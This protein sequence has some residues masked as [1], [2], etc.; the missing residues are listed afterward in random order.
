LLKANEENHENSTRILID[1]FRN[2]EQKF[3]LSN[4][5]SDNTR[6]LI[7]LWLYK[8][9]RKEVVVRRGLIR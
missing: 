2:T 4:G 5:M 7:S 1:V 8:E 9:V 6:G 3:H